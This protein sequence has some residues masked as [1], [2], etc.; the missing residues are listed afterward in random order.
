MDRGKAA[1]SFTFPCGCNSPQQPK[2]DRPLDRTWVCGP[3]RR[4]GAFTSTGTG[5]GEA[6]LGLAVASLNDEIGNVLPRVSMKKIS[7]R[8]RRHNRG[9]AEEF[10]GRR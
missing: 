3:L 1:R 10:C 5:I 6:A 7:Q 8:V 4:F 2:K 9:V